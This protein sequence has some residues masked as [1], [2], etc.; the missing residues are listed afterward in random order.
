MS[1]KH[2]IDFVR[3]I[4]LEKEI[5]L[6]SDVYTGVFQKL[7]VRCLKCNFNSKDNKWMPTFNNVKNMNQGCPNCAKER[8]RKKESHSD[9]FVDQ[10]CFNAGIKLLSKYVNAKQKLKLKCLKCDNMFENNFDHIKNKKQGCPECGKE[11]RK[12]TMLKRFGVDN[13]MKN[14]SIALKSAKSS[15]NSSILYHWKTRRRI[16]LC[17]FI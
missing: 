4:C 11:K 17:W 12:K 6:L 8:I 7:K 9:S 16:S 1:K 2:T 15:N 13:A 5:D 10:F 3:Q 14:K